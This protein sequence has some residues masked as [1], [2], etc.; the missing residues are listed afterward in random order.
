MEGVQVLLYLCLY[1]PGEE[2]AELVV[3]PVLHRRRPVLSPPLDS[4]DE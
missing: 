2:L 3:L 1:Q 4:E